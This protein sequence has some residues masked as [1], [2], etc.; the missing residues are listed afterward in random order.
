[1]TA[2]LEQEALDCLKQ[3]QDTGTAGSHGVE[4]DAPADSER[5]L[6]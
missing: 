1:M 2:G 5:T 6:T 4:P 3:G